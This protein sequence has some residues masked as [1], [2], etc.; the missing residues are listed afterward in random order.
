MSG[1]PATSELERLGVRRLSAGTAIAQA[2]QS[3]PREAARDFLGTRE[4]GATAFT[5]G[6][7]NAL[8]RRD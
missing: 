4:Q 6:D 1:L 3:G 7:V 2:V 8:T 5:T